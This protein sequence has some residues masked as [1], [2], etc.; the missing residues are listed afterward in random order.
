MSDLGA[1][2][3]R[4]K[5]EMSDLMGSQATVDKSLKGIGETG[6]AVSAKLQSAYAKVT[7]A[8]KRVE[9]AQAQAALAMQRAQTSAHDDSLSLEQVQVAMA[10]ADLAA[11]RVTTSQAQVAMAMERADIM[12]RNLATAETQVA[13]TSERAGMSLRE[14][15]SGGLNTVSEAGNGFMGRMRG[16]VGGLLDF[17]SKL[18]MTLFSLQMFAQISEQV[19]QALI[20]QDASMEQTTVAFTGLL[21]GAKAAHDELANI[22]TL[23]DQTPFEFPDIASAERKLLAFN[24]SLRDTHPLITDISDMLSAMGDTTSASLD[25]VVTVFGQINAAGRLQTQD[26]MQLQNVGINA[27]G[28]IAQ[29]MGKPESTIREMVTKGLIPASDGIKMLEA[30]IHKT[31]GGESAKQAET[32]NGI[33]STMKDGIGKAWQAFTGPAFQDAKQAL[34][35]LG[36]LVSSQ[37]FKDFA[38][39]MGDKVG[40]ALKAVGEAVGAVVK[41]VKSPEFAELGKT[42]GQI[43]SP[44]AN[45]SKTAMQSLQGIKIGDI[46]AGLKGAATDVKEFFQAL[47]GKGGDSGFAKVGTV[48]KSL[49]DAAGQLYTILAGSLGPAF[50]QIGEFITK[51]LWPSLQQSWKIIMENKD[52]FILLGQIIGGALLV[53][54]GL[55][56]GALGGVTKAIAGML[57]GFTLAFAGILQFGKGVVE[58]FGSTF[59]LLKDLF[60]GNFGA[61]GKDW[62]LFKQG[63]VDTVSGLGNLIIGA[64]EGFFGMIGGFTSGFVDTITGYFQG[65][66]DTLVG[67][68]IVPDMINRIVGWF[69]GLP[70]RAV[71]AVSSLAGKLRDFFSGLAGQ[72]YDWGANIA[73]NVADGIRNNLPGG[74]HLPGFAAGG[75]VPQTGM[76]TVGERGPETVVLPGG[77]HVYPHG[78]GPGG[79]SSAA[80]TAAA[81][82]V[83]HV[84]NHNQVIIDGQEMGEYSGSHQARMVRLHQARRVV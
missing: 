29:A 61:L 33:V 44:L 79:Y 40:G 59:Q 48:M 20:G 38:K 47:Q 76:Y 22:Q 83:V 73:N 70:G 39:T 24:F 81:A 26:L 7:E 37:Q 1:M 16:M 69:L 45:A 51:D 55:L 4:Y 13:E 25:Q 64:F 53:A 21:H 46:T 36:G 68:S 57:P 60:T 32:F 66:S 67:H 12:A 35:S 34:Q 42:L 6:N 18:G 62:D 11:E 28:L 19:G 56:V 41:A 77:S 8:T 52:S 2:V 15:F 9:V 17:G 82:P 23:A 27:F 84:H 5:V 58:I 72:A 31:F 43:F 14:S 30:G 63:V 78:M 80:T 71:D 10:K 49:G 3:V 50:A 75:D 54:L 65:L 74:I